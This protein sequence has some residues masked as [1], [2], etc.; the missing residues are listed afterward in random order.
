MI[1]VCCWYFL[2]VSISSPFHAVVVG[3]FSNQKDCEAYRA[4]VSFGRTYSCYYGA[5]R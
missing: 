5:G 3:P 4:E 2:M 1:L